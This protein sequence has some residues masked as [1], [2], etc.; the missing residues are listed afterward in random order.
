MSKRTRY[1][2]AGMLAALA[3]AAVVAGGAL[4]ASSASEKANLKANQV[5]P[6]PGQDG[7]SGTATL[8]ISKPKAQI[9][10]EI[11]FKKI[12]KPNSAELH[13]GVKGEKGPN[14]LDFF[15]KTTSSPASGKIKEVEAG[16]L[17]KLVNHP[18]NFYVQLHSPGTYAKGSIRGQL[19]FDSSTGE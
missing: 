15:T 7:G 18:E 19:K 17:K 12:D 16:L 1:L 6:G 8:E 14:K 10:Y 2:I 4:G 13:K 5:V 3:L 9:K 11:T